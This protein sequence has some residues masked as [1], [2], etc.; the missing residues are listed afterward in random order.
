MKKHCKNLKWLSLLAVAGLVSFNAPGQMPGVGSSTG[1]N[2]ALIKLFGAANA[3][4]AKADIRVLD[5]TQAEQIITPMN[6]ALLDGK[7]RVDIDLTQ[8]KGQ[9]IP[10]GMVEML[11]KMGMDKMVSIVRPDR[12]L[13]Y[14]I[15][16]EQK[17][18]LSMPMP[19]EEAEAVGKTPKIEKAILGKETVDGHACIKNKVVMTDDSGHKIEAIT[20]NASDLKEFPVQVQSTDNGNTTVVKFKNVQFVKTEEKDFD[21]PTDFKQYSSAQEMN[22]AMMKK[23][24]GAADGK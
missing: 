20:W 21:P 9:S 4:T 18:L 11:K 14:I 24:L 3:F 7:V 22:E 6:F 17:S 15:Y 16:P 13:V 12:K 5:S 19:K 2:A 8:V 23:M 10:E 1:L